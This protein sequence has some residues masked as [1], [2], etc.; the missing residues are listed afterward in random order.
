MYNLLREEVRLVGKGSGAWERSQVWGKPGPPGERGEMMK[1]Q[2][3]CTG[4]EWDRPKLWI[5]SIK[6][7][8]L[9]D[10]QGH[11]LCWCV[12]QLHRL[13]SQVCSEERPP[14]CRAMY[15]NYLYS[16]IQLYTPENEWT[17]KECPKAKEIRKNREKRPR[18]TNRTANP[19]NNGGTRCLKYLSL[20]FQ[21]GG[22]L[23]EI[24]LV[25][26]PD[27]YNTNCLNYG[28]EVWP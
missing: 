6:P 24:S 17:I 14:A 23:S 7:P 1:K 13:C 19:R 26:H 8:C 11:Q 27:S 25:W 21:L 16:P 12:P 5:P 3:Q 20:G 4:K 9:S 2:R 10:P 15:I 28:T 22:G 18:R